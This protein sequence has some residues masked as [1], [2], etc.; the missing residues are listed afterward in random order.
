[1]ALGGVLSATE[2][3]DRPE[4]ELLLCCASTGK[5]SDRATRIAT[6]LDEGIDWTYLLQT[7]QSHGTSSLLYWSLKNVAFPEA[8]PT[9][10]MDWLQNHFQSNGRN[11]LF[12]T[13]ALLKILDELAANGIRAIPYKGPTLAVVAYGNLALREFCD[14]DILLRESDVPK[15]TRVLTSLEYHPRDKLT[16]A[17]EAAFLRHAR[18]YEF[19]NDDGTLVE[20]QWKLI[21]RYFT[22]PLTFKH[23]W[24][25]TEQ[26]SLGGR[27]V[28]TFSSEDLLLILCVHGAMHCWERL[29]WICDVARLVRASSDMDWERLIERASAFNAKR[30]LLLGLFLANQLLDADL[31]ESVLR[32]VRADRAVEALAGEVRKRLFLEAPD[33][34]RILEGSTFNGFHLQ[35]VERVQDK[36][37]YCVQ[38]AVTPTLVDWRRVALPAILF[39]VYYLLRP[40]WLA[41]Q[42]GLKVAK[43]WL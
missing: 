22:F 42:L 36:L 37:W 38:R 29:G 35:A 9:D 27:T 19:I 14:L 40:I 25:R 20:L 10:V 6:L 21:P 28:E 39:P 31:E 41:G 33:S 13:G 7:A 30:M 43:R 3:V 4:V 8:V 1:M 12:S 2:V 15:A 23:L 5:D 32:E 24:E 11:N 16:E 18:Q 34:Q 17:Q 26:I